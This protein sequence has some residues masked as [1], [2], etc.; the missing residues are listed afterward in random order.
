MTHLNNQDTSLELNTNNK[1]KRY[2][3]VCVCVC[4]FVYVSVC[5]H[6]CV[7]VCVRVHAVG[8]VYDAC[9]F[10][11]QYMHEYDAQ[12]SCVSLSVFQR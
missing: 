2:M 4:V 3:I 9:V 10:H 1:I 8:C 11:I 5:L 12:T 7:C 6:V